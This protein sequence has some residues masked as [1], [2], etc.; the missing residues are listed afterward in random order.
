MSYARG[1]RNTSAM[2]FNIFMELKEESAVVRLGRP[3]APE[4]AI[5]LSFDN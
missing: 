3:C 5:H 1:E 4:E 2:L